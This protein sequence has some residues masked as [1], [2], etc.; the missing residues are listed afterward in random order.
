MWMSTFARFATRALSRAMACQ[1]LRPHCRPGKNP[2]HL[3]SCLTSVQHRGLQSVVLASQHASHQVVS[4]VRSLDEERLLE[5]EWEDG[6]QS[7]YPFTWLRD[8]CQCPL[9]TLQSAQARELL[10]CDLDIHTGVDTVKVTND[11][12]V[13]WVTGFYFLCNLS[14]D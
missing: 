11:N 12:K 4:H 1:A 5:V 2:G 3:P 13:S 9:C 7:L 6:G 14:F 8:N 10:M